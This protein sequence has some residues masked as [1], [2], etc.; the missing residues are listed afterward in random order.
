MVQTRRDDGNGLQME[1]CLS[2]CFQHRLGSSVQ[3]QSDLR[4]LADS[5][6]LATHQL[7]RNDCS[8]LSASNLPAGP[9]RTPCASPLRLHDSGGLY[10]LPRQAHLETP[11]QD[12]KAPLGVGTSQPT[13]IEGSTRAW[14]A[15]PGNRHTISEQCPLRRVDTP[16][17]NSSGNLGDLWQGRG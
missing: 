13:F 1:G 15:E 4:L 7:P 16:P 9:D 6:R 14:R 8:M 10:K 5:R 11:F 12:G 17:A 2:R 3:G